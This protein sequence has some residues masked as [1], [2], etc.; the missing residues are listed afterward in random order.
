MDTFGTRLRMALAN[1]DMSQSDLCRIADIDRGSMSHYVNDEFT[2]KLY[3]LL[4]ICKGLGVKPGELLDG[5]E[6]D[7]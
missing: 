2:P 6:E 1:K 5:L 4:R 7:I 3:K